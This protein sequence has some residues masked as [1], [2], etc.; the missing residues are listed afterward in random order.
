MKQNSDGFGMERNYCV[1]NSSLYTRK[2]K[3]RPVGTMTEVKA[4]RVEE[5]GGVRDRER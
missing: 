2:R 4:V 1:N 3:N 5:N